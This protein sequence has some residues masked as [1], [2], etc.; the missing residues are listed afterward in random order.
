MSSHILQ[1]NFSSTPNVASDWNVDSNTES[2]ADIYSS[3]IKNATGNLSMTLH[4]VKGKKAALFMSVIAG[5]SLLSI[6][7]FIAI[8]LIV[9]RHKLRQKVVNIYAANTVASNLFIFICST[10]SAWKFI[11]VSPTMPIYNQS[12]IS[13]ALLYFWLGF[14]TLIPLAT[15]VNAGS[16]ALVIK[17][18]TDDI[19]QMHRTVAG[20]VPHNCH[21]P[22]TGNRENGCLS[23]LKNWTKR[24]KHRQAK[25]MIAMA[26]F[27]PAALLPILIYDGNCIDEC[28]CLFTYVP[29]DPSVPLCPPAKGCY[30]QRAPMTKSSVLVISSVWLTYAFTLLVVCL[31]SYINFKLLVYRQNLPAKTQASRSAVA[32]VS[33]IV[34]ETNNQEMLERNNDM[35]DKSINI[36]SSLSKTGMFQRNIKRKIVYLIII[37]ILFVVGSGS[38]VFSSLAAIARLMESVK[39]LGHQPPFWAIGFAVQTALSLFLCSTLL[40]LRNAVRAMIL[41]TIACLTWPVT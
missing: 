29:S 39:T 17:A 20:L 40:G 9:Y 28:A 35:D 30:I 2:Y 8:S 31:R 22:C 5:T 37:S 18:L 1:E 14:Q 34:S 19:I 15:V 25:I 12:N 4:C 3:A 7:L 27:L 21:W 13:R 23:R 26:W 36:Q 6:H 24:H 33:G 10:S 11:F 16:I 38:I 32:S 41:K